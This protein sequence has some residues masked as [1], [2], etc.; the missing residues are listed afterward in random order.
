M[1]FRDEL[2]R[3]R[4]AASLTQEALAQLVGTSV[5]NIRN[6]EQGASLPSLPAAVRL[7]AALGVDCTVFAK[8]EDVKE[9]GKA[10]SNKKQTTKK[11]KK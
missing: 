6:Y 10:E 3:L 7:A 11:G 9:D 4:T 2:K 8:C 5:G 1:L